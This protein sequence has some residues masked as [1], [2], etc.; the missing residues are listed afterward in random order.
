[1]RDPQF[2]LDVMI[3]RMREAARRR[4]EAL[5]KFYKIEFYDTPLRVRRPGRSARK[6][7]ERREREL[8]AQ[9]QSEP[10]S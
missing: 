2:A 9:S 1:M 8:A 6:R 10:Q 7:A 4:G 3:S 5:P